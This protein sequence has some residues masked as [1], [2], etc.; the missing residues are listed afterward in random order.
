VKANST[1][2]I[3]IAASRNAIARRLLDLS[4]D[5]SWWPGA[6]ATGEY[7]RVVVRAPAGARAPKRG[8]ARRARR[9]VTF[10]AGIGPVREWDGFTW[11]LERGA[12]AGR[13]EW[14]FEEFK[15]GTIVHHYLDAERGNA[16][17]WRRMP[18]V[19][20]RYRWAIRGCLNALK[21]DLESRQRAG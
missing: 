14:W 19:V 4:T 11:F 18:S 20:R 3:Y 15:D 17:K 8:T 10:E 21:D 5:A 16:R 1:D 13:A 2:E 6:R 7:G 9:A 12:L